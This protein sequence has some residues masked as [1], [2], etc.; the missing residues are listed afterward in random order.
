MTIF[1]FFH[2]VYLVYMRLSL[3][4]AVAS[5]AAL[6]QA[7][8]PPLP[9]QSATVRSA[10][11]VDANMGSTYDDLAKRAAAAAAKLPND[12]SQWWI[13]VAGGPG[14]GKSTLSEAVAAKCNE[15]GVPAVVLPMDGFHYSRA[16]LRELDPPNAESYLPRRGAPWTFAAESLF[17]QLSIARS[18]KASSLPTY[19]RE[20]SDPV[21]GGVQLEPWHRVVLVEGNYL[22]LG[23]CGEVPGTELTEAEAARWKPLLPLFDERW[24]VSP[25]GGVEEQRRRLIDRHLETWTDAKT[26]LFKSKTAK[27]GAA[28]RADMNDVLNARVVDAC[29]EHAD[30][31]IE[32]C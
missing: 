25:K 27:D 22:L 9:R 29:R 12:G 1:N 5:T 32:S 11:P 6:C 21:Q 4:A 16:E 8:Q 7:Y 3:V 23:A 26:A 18:E 15:M 13:C 30:V 2:R 14:A 20:K 10:A 24:F 31:A 19:S 28:K 17:E